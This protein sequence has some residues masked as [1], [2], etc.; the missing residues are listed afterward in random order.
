MAYGLRYFGEFEDISGRSYRVEILQKEYTGSFY[1]VTLGSSPII[2]T[3]QTDD[4]RATV[5]GSSAVVNI[6]NSGSIP[7]TT[8]YSVNDD[9][10]Q[11]KILQG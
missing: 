9:E 2:H 4:I 11:V 5:R 7:I 3:Y 8:F 6:I 10:F 1:S